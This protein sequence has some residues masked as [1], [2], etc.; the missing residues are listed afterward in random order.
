[1]LEFKDVY[2]G[3]NGRDIIKDINFTIKRGES[4]AI[5]GPNSCG[6]TTLLRAA[7]GII[8]HRGQISL[9]GSAIDTMK[10]R[11]I[12]EH[13]AMMSQINHV[14][15]PYSIY[16]TVMMGRYRFLRKNL[17][18]RPGPQDIKIVEETLE[19]TSLMDIKDKS[20]NILSGGQLQ[21]V[22]LAHTLVQEPEL[23]L[24]DEPTNHM[25][26]KYQI[27]V[28]NFLKDW[29][30]KEGKAVVGVFHDINL[31]MELTDNLMF[32]KEGRIHGMGSA[33]E[34]ITST[35]LEEIYEMDIVSY[36]VRSLE[37]WKKFEEDYE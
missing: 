5:I 14:H 37:R 28:V 27:D 2:A 7:A 23:I 11:D 21:R 22:Y 13:I 19:K 12:A 29:A 20:L 17:F 15:F 33:Q 8:Q 32:M 25:D 18:G 16:E 36:M 1:M 30:L 6:K 9:S 10:R 35:F 26:V 3:Y 4:L 31:A 34:L 24:L